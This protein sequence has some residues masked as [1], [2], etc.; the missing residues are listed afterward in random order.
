M[1]I[2][3]DLFS[4]SLSRASFCINYVKNNVV[5]IMQC[6]EKKLLGNPDLE[7]RRGSAPGPLPENFDLTELLKMS[8]ILK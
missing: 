3:K 5:K 4:Q 1:L 8:P 7:T 2:K 6:C